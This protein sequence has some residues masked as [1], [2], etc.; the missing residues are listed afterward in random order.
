MMPKETFLT[1]MKFHKKFVILSIK[2]TIASLWKNM[3]QQIFWIL[4]YL[5]SYS[6]L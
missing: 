1:D 4:L 6:S 5:Q 2:L 3:I